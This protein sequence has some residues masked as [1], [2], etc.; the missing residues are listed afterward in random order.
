M[1]GRFIHEVLE[2]AR[3]PE[4]AGAGV[5]G[6]YRKLGRQQ[7]GVDPGLRDLSRNKLP[8][9]HVALERCAIAMEEHD[10][11][12]GFADVESF[13]HVHQHAVVVVG[14]VLPVDPPRVAAVA[15]ALALDDVQEWFVGARVVAEIGEGRRFQPHQGCL[16]LVKA[17]LIRHCRCEGSNAIRWR[18]H[19]DARLLSVGRRRQPL[20][21]AFGGRRKAIPKLRLPEAILEAVASRFLR[22]GR[23]RAGVRRLSAL[24]ED[25]RQRN[26]RCQGGDPVQRVR[27]EP[28]P[29]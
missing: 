17:A 23:E 28:K 11:D 25:K 26:Q 19:G 21:Q 22:I 9:T 18:L 13:G 1:I 14:L 29:R 16:F 6:V 20:R 4:F 3:L 2:P 7:N 5:G 10:D 24:N 12:A 8:V 15:A 27:C